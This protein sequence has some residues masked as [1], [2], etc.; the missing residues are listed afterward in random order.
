MSLQFDHAVASS[1][2]VGVAADCRGIDLVEHPRHAVS[3]DTRK[4][5]VG[6][7]KFDGALYR[8]PIPA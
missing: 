7:E 5:I 8:N 2:V 3:G 6:A 1:P 4:I